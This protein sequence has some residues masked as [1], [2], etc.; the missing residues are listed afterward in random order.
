MDK[1]HKL[2]WPVYFK[3]IK[4]IHSKILH[5]LIVNTVQPNM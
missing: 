2:K 4:M 1:D 3:Y 5:Q